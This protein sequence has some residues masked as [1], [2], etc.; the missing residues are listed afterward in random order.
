M[1]PSARVSPVPAPSPCSSPPDLP[2]NFNYIIIISVWQLPP[3]QPRPPPRPHSFALSIIK[4]LRRLPRRQLSTFALALPQAA[5]PAVALPRCK[6]TPI[7]ANQII[8]NAQ[9]NFWP[10]QRRC[11][12][13]SPR[14]SCRR[15]RLTCQ[16]SPFPPLPS[17]TPRSTY[18]SIKTALQF[19]GNQYA[20][21]L[22]AT[23]EAVGRAEVR[24]GSRSSWRWR[25]G[26]SR[27]GQATLSLVGTFAITT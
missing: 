23:L 20:R 1:A 26:N 21:A 14:C 16:S 22:C 7:R 19:A 25:W 3:T 10:S 11:R 17:C 18:N 12:P 2:I 4:S 15:R 27:R 8:Y 24:M 13:R 5:S 6:F 9:P